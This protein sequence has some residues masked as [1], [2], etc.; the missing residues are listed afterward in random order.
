[1]KLKTL[2]FACALLAMGL[3][4][5]CDGPASTDTKVSNA[6][7]QLTAQGSAQVGLPGITNFTE[8]KIV[9]KLYELRDQS[10][11]TFSY[12]PDMQGRLWHVCDSIGFGLPY[13][14]QFSNPQRVAAQYQGVFGT[15]PQAEPNGLFM[16]ETAEGT[17]I[18]CSDPNKKGE[19]QPVYIEPRVVVSPFK[20][21]SFGEWGQ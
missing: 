2:A 19:I 1:M 11:A 17:W 10:V 9:R 21:K 18:I 8:M 5:G 4:V 16:P 14:V 12:V 6:Q 3:V 7:A 13:G 15:L 20:L